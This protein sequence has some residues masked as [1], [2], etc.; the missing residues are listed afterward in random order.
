[1]IPARQYGHTLI[2]VTLVGLI[3]AIVAVLGARAIGQHQLKLRQLRGQAALIGAAQ[4]MEHFHVMQRRYDRSASGQPTVLPT[5]FLAG[6]AGEAEYSLVF[7]SLEAQAYVL[8]A[9]PA[10]SWSGDVCGSLVLDHRGMRSHRGSA[11]SDCWIL[12]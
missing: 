11:Q 7:E 12:R 2:E 9:V 8:L 3:V 5:K 6:D 1:M 4:W 10:V